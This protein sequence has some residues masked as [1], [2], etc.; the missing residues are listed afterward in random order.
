VSVRESNTG[1]KIIAFSIGCEWS[2]RVAKKGVR[3]Q[4]KVESLKFNEERKRSEEDNAG[5][6]A[7]RWR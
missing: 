3:E 2:V 7:Q 5:T 4:L 1:L 6:W